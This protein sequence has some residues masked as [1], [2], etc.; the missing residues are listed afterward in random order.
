MR[1]VRGK[2][3]KPEMKVRSTLHAAGYR[4]R[5]HRR[6]LP[7]SPDIVL[8]RFQ[9]AVWVNGC[10]WHGHDC[11][12]GRSRPSVN[13]KFWNAKI[14]RTIERDRIGENAAKAAGW[15]TWIIW[16]CRL[17]NDLRDL[18]L[19]LSKLR[20]IRTKRVAKILGRAPRARSRE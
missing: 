1:R 11:R 6:D 12:K 9:L 16:E 18:L 10:F 15:K 8:A 4:F 2:D 7:G 5:L 13:S 14:N 19:E 17:D 3:T 20:S